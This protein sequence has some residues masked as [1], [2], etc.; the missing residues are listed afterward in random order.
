MNDLG[1]TGRGKFVDFCEGPSFLFNSGRFVGMAPV[2]SIF[3][4]SK[5]KAESSRERNLKDFLLYTDTENLS[6]FWIPNNPPKKPP[7]EKHPAS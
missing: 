1:L 5:R 4:Q 2:S 7:F 3:G 6:C